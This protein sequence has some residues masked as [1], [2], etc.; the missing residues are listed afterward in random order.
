[1][2]KTSIQRSL[3]A[4][5]K[6][7]AIAVSLTI[8]GQPAGAQERVCGNPTEETCDPIQDQAC[9]T[10]LYACGHYELVVGALYAETYAPTPTQ[11]FFLGAALYGLHNQTRAK[12]L[13]CEFALSAKDTLSSY[14]GDKQ[15]RL[16][17]QGDVGSATEITQIYQAAKMVEDLGKIEGCVESAVTRASLIRL[18]RGESLTLVKSAFL[19]PPPNVKAQMDTIFSVL[20]RVVSQVSDIETS[21]AMRVV[22]IQSGKRYRDNVVMGMSA[23]FGP[24]S[25]SGDQLSVSTAVIAALSLKTL[26]WADRLAQQRE[27]FRQ[28]LGG[29]SMG[30]YSDIRLRTLQ[31]ADGFLKES[32]IYINTGGRLAAADKSDGLS[33]FQAGL[34]ALESPVMAAKRQISTT[35]RDYGNAKGY[36]ATPLAERRWFCQ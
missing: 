16:E 14:L 13:K 25:G 8:S 12:S 34:S 24:V 29:I 10:R 32:A 30:E 28:A 22:E 9:L 15:A 17:G 11:R 20:R 21:L 23:L 27:R 36:C 35:W 31:S 4:G 1:M 26:A 7:A 33:R 18:A 3:R 5:L 19:N 6:T 2:K